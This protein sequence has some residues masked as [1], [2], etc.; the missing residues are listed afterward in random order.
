MQKSD[1]LK[2]LWPHKPDDDTTWKYSDVIIGYNKKTN[3]L[4]V[5]EWVLNPDFKYKHLDPNYGK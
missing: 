2:K 4:Y 5:K 1:S 3:K